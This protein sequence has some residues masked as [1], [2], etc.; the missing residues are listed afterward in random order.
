MTLK[1]NDE[2]DESREFWEFVDQ[3][4]EEVK[5]WPNWKIGGPTLPVTQPEKAIEPS[6][7]ADERKSA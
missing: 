1:R 2:N 5:K 6:P 7:Q 4:A 3:A